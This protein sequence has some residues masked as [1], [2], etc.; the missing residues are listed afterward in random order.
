MQHVHRL[1]LR[2]PQRVGRYRGRGCK[3]RKDRDD[4][5]FHGNPLQTLAPLH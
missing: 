5:W 4:K 2:K 3:T 1:G